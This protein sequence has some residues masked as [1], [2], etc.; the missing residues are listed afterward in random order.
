MELVDNACKKFSE[1]NNIPYEA[2]EKDV[3]KL[4]AIEM[5]KEMMSDEISRNPRKGQ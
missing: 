2:I 5:Y 1:K 4:V 3:K